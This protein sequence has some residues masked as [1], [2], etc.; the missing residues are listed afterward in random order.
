MSVPLWVREAAD[1]FWA[2]A[3][4][5][6]PFPRTLRR[7]VAQALP[8]SVVYLSYL[9]IRAVERW[10]RQHAAYGF[11]E[12]PDRPL[13]AC[14][15]CRFGQ[16]IIFV[17]GTDDEYEQRVSLAHE[18]SHFL[19]DYHRPRHRA[20]E[21]VGTDVLPV[22]DG[23]RSARTEERLAGLLSHVDVRSYVHLMDR[24]DDR[25]RSRIEAAEASA[26]RLA[27]ELLAPWESLSNEIAIRDLANQ[28]QGI[29]R[30]LQ[31]KYGLPEGA[32]GRYLQLMKPITPVESSLLRH[33]RS[34][35]V[36]VELSLGQSE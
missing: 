19:R 15:F 25:A 24:L 23:S 26:D 17:D 29:L 10:L 20:T 8:I 5:L 13:R 11:E 6:E 34:E 14:L 30:L 9:S 1:S 12:M 22:L 4:E 18:V 3:G 2:A 16:G 21:L 31:T 28:P 27:F 32:A 36:P 33:L 35:L 7:S